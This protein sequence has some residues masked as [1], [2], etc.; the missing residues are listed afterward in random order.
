MGISSQSSASVALG[1][2][3]PNWFALFVG[4]LSNHAYNPIC[5]TA[6]TSGPSSTISAGHRQNI[7][8]LNISGAGKLHPLPV[9]IRD[10]FDA[11][12]LIEW[13]TSKQL[14]IIVSDFVFFFFICPSHYLVGSHICFPCGMPPTDRPPRSGQVPRSNLRWV[15]RYFSFDSL[16]SPSSHHPSSRRTL[17]LLAFSAPAHQVIVRGIIKFDDFITVSS[18]DGPPRP[19]NTFSFLRERALQLLCTVRDNSSTVVVNLSGK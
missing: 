15:P 19:T 4:N 18:S 12:V 2:P 10:S 11:I 16:F 13:E 3:V 6:R 5:R 7:R 1:F 17:Y 9:F 14:I 8:V